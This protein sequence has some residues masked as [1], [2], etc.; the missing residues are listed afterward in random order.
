[1]HILKGI[2]WWDVSAGIEGIA[3]PQVL[4]G[5]RGRKDGSCCQCTGCNLCSPLS[6]SLPDAFDVLRQGF[7]CHVDRTSNTR[8][9]VD[10][11][12]KHVMS[13]FSR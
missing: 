9:L 12:E 5:E 13:Y 3:G 6:S 11:M 8:R 7:S 1:M 4:G 10:A 2:W